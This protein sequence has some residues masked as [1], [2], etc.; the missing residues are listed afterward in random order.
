MR[1]ALSCRG[2]RPRR[3]VLS[4]VQS[5]LFAQFGAFHKPCRGAAQF[6][7]C[8]N[9]T[10]R[11]PDVLFTDSFSLHHVADILPHFISSSNKPRV[12]QYQINNKQKRQNAK[13]LPNAL[14]GR[15]FLL[16]SFNK[17]LDSVRSV[18]FVH[19]ASYCWIE[20]IIDV[21]VAVFFLTKLLR[22]GLLGADVII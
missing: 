3:P 22:I 19:L 4:P 13:K 12:K 11:L 17:F 7:L 18:F 9:A 1:I 5:A 10:S 14:Y 8:R 16:F 6:L 2:R 15:L 21:D 20:H